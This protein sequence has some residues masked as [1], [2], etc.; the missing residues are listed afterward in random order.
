[1][2]FHYL[3]AKTITLSISATA[4]IINGCREQKAR[5]FEAKT[6]FDKVGIWVFG[7]I[8][9]LVNPNSTAAIGRFNHAIPVI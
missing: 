1:M 6:G 9:V 7:T 2:T 8:C 5:V 4:T 3:P